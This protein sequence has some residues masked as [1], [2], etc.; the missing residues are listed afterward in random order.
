MRRHRLAALAALALAVVPLLLVLVPLLPAQDEHAEA[1]VE[2]P[3]VTATTVPAPPTTRYTS[4]PR[5]K[6]PVL[7][8][9]GYDG[10]DHAYGERVQ[11][12]PWTFPP[13]TANGCDWLRQHGFGPL[14][15][16]GHD[17]HG[18]DTNGDGTACG[19]GDR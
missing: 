8:P 9:G 4:P 19:R 15:V 16:R 6:T 13:G 17:R 14:T 18:L 5:P 2:R 12:V 1:S 10:C 7:L 3:L 11:C